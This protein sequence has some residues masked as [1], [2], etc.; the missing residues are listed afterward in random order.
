MDPKPILVNN[1][2]FFFHISGVKTKILQAV[3]KKSTKHSKWIWETRGT[4]STT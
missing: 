3:L 2:F 4:N 1:F